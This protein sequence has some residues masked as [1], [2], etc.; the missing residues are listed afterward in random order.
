MTLLRRARSAARAG[1]VLA[2]R[3][4]PAVRLRVLFEDGDEFGDVRLLRFGNVR[5]EGC[6]GCPHLA[7]VRDLQLSTVIVRCEA[8]WKSEAEGNAPAAQKYLQLW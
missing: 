8:Q 3:C 4:K 1:A 5:T 7:V 2:A 6:D